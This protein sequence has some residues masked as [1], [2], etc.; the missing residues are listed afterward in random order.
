MREY[1]FADRLI[2]NL[3]NFIVTNFGKP[4]GTNRKSPANNIEESELSDSEKQ[5]SAA[6]M[7]INHCG[8]VC[9]QAL[10]Q[11]QAITARKSETREELEH[12]S[13]EENDHLIWCEQRIK[14]LGGRTS[15]LNPIWYTSSFAIGTFAGLLGD[16]W[17][18]GFL[19]ETEK[20]VGKHLQSHLDKISNK[21]KKTKAI[22]EQ[23]YID[24]TSHEQKA[25][26]LGAAKFPFVVKKAMQAMSKV[27]TTLT[28]KI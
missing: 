24:E 10:Y 16:K 1:S 13:I 6:L 4:Q 9:A 21:D 17:S 5:H 8:E 19:S 12:A 22:I 25:I 20:Q 14:E 18:L 2:N 26:E 15:Y 3:D 11:G 23:M 7:R 28:Y 27:M